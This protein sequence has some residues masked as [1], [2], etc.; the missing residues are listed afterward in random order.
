M[1]YQEPK[2]TPET[3]TQK[4]RIIDPRFD[5]IGDLKKRMAIMERIQI[6][7]SQ[8]LTGFIEDWMR[9]QLDRSETQNDQ[10]ETNIGALEEALV[11]IRKKREEL[12]HQIARATGPDFLSLKVLDDILENR[13][14]KTTQELNAAKKSKRHAEEHVKSSSQKLKA[15]KMGPQTGVP[16]LPSS[17][18]VKWGSGAW[19]KQGIGTDFIRVIV[20]MLGLELIRSGLIPLLQRAFGNP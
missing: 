5:E 12:I 11:E 16:P 13:Q 6:D 7:T 19:F 4:Q 10:A 9:E 15:I 20:L 18:P 14:L 8:R 17:E 1:T 2:T 3:E